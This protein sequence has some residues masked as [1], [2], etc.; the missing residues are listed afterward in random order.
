MSLPSEAL[1]T[2]AE[3]VAKSRELGHSPLVDSWR[4]LGSR[5]YA[6]VCELCGDVIWVVRG[7]QE[8]FFGGP[9]ARQPCKKQAQASR[10]TST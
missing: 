9:A 7:S 4:L 5:M 1:A 10:E 6:T 3:G 2:A 8:W